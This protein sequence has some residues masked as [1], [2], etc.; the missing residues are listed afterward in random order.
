MASLLGMQSSK[1]ELILP[2]T[3]SE[4]TRLVVGSD[5]D[6]GLLG[7]L[8]IELI[9]YSDGLV[10]IDDLMEYGSGIVG[11]GCIVNL[12]ALDHEEEALAVVEHLDTCR[13]EL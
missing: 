10:K 11:M 12:A 4:S 6:E 3:K 9:G 5:D 13:Y 8:Q 7:M 1:V 2:V